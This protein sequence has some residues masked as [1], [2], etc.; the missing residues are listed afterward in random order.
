MVVDERLFYTESRTTKPARLNCPFCR[1]V[2][3]YELA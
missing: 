2:E 1:S 3:E